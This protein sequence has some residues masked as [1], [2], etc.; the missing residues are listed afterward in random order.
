[1]HMDLFSRQ[2]RNCGR[3]DPTV[4][5]M[6]SLWQDELIDII[7]MGVLSVLRT[8]V[9]IVLSSIW[10]SR[11]AYPSKDQEIVRGWE[12][13][14]RRQHGRLHW[15]PEGYIST[16]CTEEYCTYG[17]WPLSGLSSEA[18]RERVG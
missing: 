9:S 1:M 5:E 13:Q 3:S 17:S 4:D 8:V 10:S 7:V 16:D 12:E 15:Q 11:Q 14:L 18:S 6:R 2:H